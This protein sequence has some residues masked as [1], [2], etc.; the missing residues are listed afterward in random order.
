MKKLLILSGLLFLSTLSFSQ[1]SFV[2]EGN[3]L[4]YPTVK[5]LIKW[6]NYSLSE[7]KNEMK[8]FDFSKNGIGK[9]GQSYYTSSLKNGSFAIERYPSKRIQ[10]IHTYY[11]DKS[12]FDKFIDEVENY[13]VKSHDG[14]L[15]EYG[16]QIKDFNYRFVV[17]RTGSMEIIDTQK[18]KIKSP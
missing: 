18:F 4:P 16:I 13:Y 7:W 1:E 9:E 3:N 6:T 5:N 17:M 2:I 12:F 14:G 8:Q 10:I 15:V 11:D